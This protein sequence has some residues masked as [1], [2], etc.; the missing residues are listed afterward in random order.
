MQGMVQCGA[1]AIAFSGN[2]G[3]EKVG[4]DTDVSCRSWRRGEHRRLLLLVYEESRA[5]AGRG[6]E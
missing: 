5:G 6:D 2:L 4:R 1:L 3:D